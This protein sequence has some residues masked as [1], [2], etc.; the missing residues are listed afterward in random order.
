MIEYGELEKKMNAERTKRGT[1]DRIRNELSGM[2]IVARLEKEKYKAALKRIY[3]CKKAGAPDETDI[4]EKLMAK[5]GRA[6][7]IT[8]V[9]G[10]R[11]QTILDVDKNGIILIS[12]DGVGRLADDVYEICDAKTNEVL[13]K[14]K[15]VGKKDAKIWVY[16]VK[17]ALEMLN[18]SSKFYEAQA[19]KLEKELA[20]FEETKE[21]GEN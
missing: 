11:T 1:K 17:K 15:Y 19:E 3:L 14:N 6:V 8:S 7:T 13:F 16:G 9:D 5:N 20:E 12:E 10:L 4:L 18:D 2:R 21:K